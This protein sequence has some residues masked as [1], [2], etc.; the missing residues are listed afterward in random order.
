M[1]LLDTSVHVI[2]LT[3]SFEQWGPHIQ[4][5]GFEKGVKRGGEVTVIIWIGLFNPLLGTAVALIAECIVSID[6]LHACIINAYKLQ[7]GFPN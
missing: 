3:G 2:I 6:V 5:A 1:V 7:E 4:F